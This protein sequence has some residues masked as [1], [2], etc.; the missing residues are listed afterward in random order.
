V[1]TDRII[2]EEF[3]ARVN[4]KRRIIAIIIIIIIIITMTRKVDCL[5]ADESVGKQ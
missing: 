1:Y 3:K 2:V 5:L 4:R